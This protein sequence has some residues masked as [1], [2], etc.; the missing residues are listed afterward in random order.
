M[1]NRSLRNAVGRVVVFTSL[2]APMTAHAETLERDAQL[3]LSA[4]GVIA[5]GKWL[6]G[7]EDPDKS[8]AVFGVKASWDLKGDATHLGIDLSSRYYAYSDEDRDD[9][10]SNRIAGIY[11]RQVAPTLRIGARADLASRMATLES[12]SANQAQIQG[13]LILGKHKDSV[14]LSAGWRWRRYRD[15]SNGSG[16]GAVA[17]I[18][19][20]RRLDKRQFLEISGSY[21]TIDST[22]DR[23]DYRRYTI[24][25]EYRLR[26]INKL[27]LGIGLALKNWSYRNRRVG[28]G[29]Q[30]DH[31]WTPK[32]NVF[33]EVAKGW[34][35]DL[36]G[37]MIS[38][39]SSDVTYDNEI[40]RVKIGIRKKLY[41]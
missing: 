34:F 38:R 12:R 5:S 21:D 40:K 36:E 39:N 16:D 35:V 4:S 13:M 33:Y 31:S 28:D 24:T 23:R 11:E 26:P 10:W 22:I 27:E 17:A 30:H 14:R 37:E 32:A 7:T 18:S 20:R 9:R 2:F 25:A 19:W 6:E 8:G 3:T 1:T 41:F 29:F 15:G